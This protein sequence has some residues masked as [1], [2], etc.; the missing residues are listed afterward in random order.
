MNRALCALTQHRSCSGAP[1]VRAPAPQRPC[2]AA[3][4]AALLGCGPNGRVRTSHV[5]RHY[6]GFMSLGYAPAALSSP[7]ATTAA[8]AAGP[9]GT[10]RPPPPPSRISMTCWRWGPSCGPAAAAAPAACHGTTLQSPCSGPWMPDWGIVR[11]QC[12]CLA[13]R[14]TVLQYEHCCQRARWGGGTEAGCG[15][16]EWAS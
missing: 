6:G 11:L 10:G 2:P 13:R 14:C 3:D 1:A 4:N 15:Q 5:Q 9:A 7:A 16:Q 8:E 12:V